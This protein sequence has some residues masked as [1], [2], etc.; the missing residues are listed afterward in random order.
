MKR[1]IPACIAALAII[2]SSCSKEEKPVSPVIKSYSRSLI[3]N[4]T[5]TV[6]HDIVPV[7]DPAG[8]ISSVSSTSYIYS[9]QENALKP[10]SSST[11]SYTYNE[12]DHTAVRVDRSEGEL[13]FFGA[14]TVTN[15]TFDEKWKL[16]S[17]FFELADLK[18]TE[19]Y[20]YQEDRVTSFVKGGTTYETTYTVK[21]ENG[22]IVSIADD[23]ETITISYL[24][25]EN[26][27]KKGMDPILFDVTSD[28][29]MYRMT[30]SHSA[31]LPA[32]Y[33]TT[34]KTKSF[35]RKYDYKKD[36]DG[37]IIEITSQEDGDGS[38]YSVSIQY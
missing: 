16:T 7:Y 11:S 29:Y 15:L 21:W 32:S 5:V 14:P 35:T 12:F 6:R 33:T 37:R 22:D 27:F 34:T 19:S 30:G 28:N 26:P 4:E 1:I 18:S 25:D 24:P 17:S 38:K 10:N 36:A 31:H 9:T 2:I 23:S 13:D 8:R 3:Q 20:T